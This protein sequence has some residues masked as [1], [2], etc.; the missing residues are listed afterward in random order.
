MTA[1]FRKVDCHS[2]PVA[3]LEAA[4]AFYR[5]GLGHELIWRDA[6]AAGLRLPDSEAEL[7]LHT[8]ER[9]VE[10]DLLVASVPAAI[11][12]FLQAGGQ[13]VAGPFEIRIGLCAMLED[14]WQNRL[15]I[16]DSSK[17]RLS[18]DAEGN[19]IGLVSPD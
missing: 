15:V 5:D 7:V 6:A 19:I 2:I 18:T 11:E 13:V 8:D 1:L 4:L 14:P 17:G 3:N 12:R 9:P 10:T 16:L